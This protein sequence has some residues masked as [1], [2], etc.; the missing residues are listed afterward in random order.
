MLVNMLKSKIHRA[1]VTAA[2]LRYVGS[3]TIDS[4]VLAAA[5][6]LAG[7]KVQVANLNTGDRFE[8]YT[9]AGEADSGV[10]C[11]N[12]AAARLVQPGDKVI[13]IAYCWMDEKEAESFT[14]TI[15]LMDENNRG[16]F[17]TPA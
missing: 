11:L 7:E 17:E 14:P 1:T 9:T 13:I 15:L 12:G 16:S 10:V 3:I 4:T 5:N 2:D 6:I 8:T